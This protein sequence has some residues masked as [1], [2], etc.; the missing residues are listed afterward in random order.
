V[1]DAIYYI[2][3]RPENVNIQDVVVMCTQQG[4]ATLYDRSGRKDA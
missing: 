4:S 2:A 3:S 1:A